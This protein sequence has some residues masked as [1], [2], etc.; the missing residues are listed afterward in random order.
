MLVGAQGLLASPRFAELTKLRENHGNSGLS[1]TISPP[2]DSS[3]YVVMLARAGLERYLAFMPAADSTSGDAATSGAVLGVVE[4]GGGVVFAVRVTPRA[5]R[6]RVQGVVEGT[7]KV[8]VAAP[9]VDGAANERLIEVLAKTLGV[10][11]SRVELQA[12]QHSRS[13]RVRVHGL[14][15][16]ELRERLQ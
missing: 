10:S 13:K 9:P 16:I 2:M 7:L 3:A 15:A 14:S 11:R 5:S 6:S 1:P 4:D 8:A 12:G